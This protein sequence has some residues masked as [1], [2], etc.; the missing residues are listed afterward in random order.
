MVDALLFDIGLVVV[1][2]TLLA[3]L[4]KAFKLQF[5]PMYMISGFIIGPLGLKLITNP[6]II[7]TLS[8][9]GVAFLLFIVGIEID[10]KRLKSIGSYATIGGFLQ[11]LVSFLFSFMVSVLL[12][13]TYMEAAF[14]GLI[15]AFSSTMVVV[16]LLSEKEQ[17]ETMPGRM[18][19]GILLMQDFLAILALSALIGFESFQSVFFVILK[20]LFLFG[21]AAFFKKIISPAIF[22][23]VGK[24]PELLF[25]S[26][27]STVFAFILFSEALGFPIAVGAFLGGLSLTA[28]PYT[29]EIVSRMS[30]LRDFFA[31]LFFVS[32]G[33]QIVLKNFL[34]FLF[35]ITLFLFFIFIIKPLLIFVI[36]LVFGYESIT[37]FTTAINLAQISEFS[38]LLASLGVLSGLVSP[39]ILSITA[40]LAMVS[41]SLTPYFVEYSNKLYILLSKHFGIFNKFDS[42]GKLENLS[43]DNIKGHVILIG[44]HILGSGLIETL[45]NYHKKILVLDHNPE[46]VK[47]LIKEGIN[48][49][50]GDVKHMEILGKLG[51]KDAALII[52]T[53]PSLEDNLFL[54][55][56]SRKMNPEVL[57]FLTANEI[58]DAL[59]AYGRGADYV[60]IPKMLGRERT[61]QYIAQLFKAKGSKG[62]LF[63]IKDKQMKILQKEN[64]IE[65]EDKHKSLY[66]IEMKKLLRS[67]KK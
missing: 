44:C 33:M 14:L 1:A 53:L 50:Y 18:M 65:F 5:I 64:E 67:F 3:F 22:R 40:V 13:F 56:E 47:R 6:Q 38:L 15:L 21:F 35:P 29:L 10:F 57:I 26:S 55:E 39:S 49:V 58:D 32:L 23:F 66:K 61:K 41:I 16:K 60:I 51:I 45:K 7:Q 31:I 59:V 9:L 43:P 46:T 36:S 54:L 20:S 24:S 63:A 62:C 8:E 17:L 19:L 12:G 42:K 28:Y 4:A 30:S 25:L 37:S 52:S 11:V 27:L 48:A 2:A 34:T